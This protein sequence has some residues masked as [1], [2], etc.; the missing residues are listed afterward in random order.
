VRLTTLVGDAGHLRTFAVFMGERAFETV[1]REDVT[2]F[3]NQRT[4]VRRW[5]SGETVTKAPKKELSLGTLNLRKVILKAFMKWL[6]GAEEYP[7]EVKWLRASRDKNAET[8]PVEQILT[9]DD[10]R[11][12]IQVQDSPQGKAIIATL[13]DSGTRA[14][15]FVSLRLRDVTFDEYGAVLTLPKDATNLKTGSRRIRVLRC[16]PYLRAWIDGH[17]R[18][19]E[20]KAPVWISTA[21]RNIGDGLQAPALNYIVDQA[22]LAAGIDKDVWPHL[23]RHSRATACAKE[24][25]PEAEMRHFFG[26]SKDSDMPSR[27]VHL[28]GKDYEENM[29]RRAGKLDGSRMA[30]P[31]LLPRICQCGHE[32]AATSDFCA[33]AVCGKP[34]TPKGVQDRQQQTFERM[35]GTLLEDPASLEKIGDAILS[36]ATKIAERQQGAKV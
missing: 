17:P 2:R 26:W 35:M 7:P 31:P 18:K 1:T 10:L 8:M 13:Y 23:F 4:S 22:A 28:S 21:V 32:N 30:P 6:R 20:G 11:R 14:S 34:L 27:Y 25:W 9:D 3:V 5:R 15:E 19:G 29:L 33:L 36:Q 24:G 16:T 12:M